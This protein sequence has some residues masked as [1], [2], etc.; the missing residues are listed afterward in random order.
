MNPQARFDA[1]E[2]LYA[3]RRDDLK[4]GFSDVCD[5]A[6]SGNDGRG[7]GSDRRPDVSGLSRQEIGADQSPSLGRSTRGAGAW[8]SKYD[9]GHHFRS[10]QPKTRPTSR[11]QRG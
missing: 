3:E 7:S 8:S 5:S 10:V 11:L 2:A 1:Y 6:D 4:G 9:A